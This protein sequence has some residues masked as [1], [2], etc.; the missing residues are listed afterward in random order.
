MAVTY[1]STGTVVFSTGN[2]SPTTPTHN[3]GDLLLLVI[4]TKPDTTPA[5]TPSGWTQL[6]VA[7]GGSGTQG[8]DTGPMRVGIFYRIADGTSLDTTGSITITGNNVSGAQ[9]HVFRS[10]TGAYDIAGVGAADTT[11]GTPFSVTMPS[12]PGLTVGD[13]LYATGIVPTDVGGGTNFSAETVSAAG[14][15]T[16]SLTETAADWASSTGQDMGGWSARGSVVTGTSTGNPTVSATVSG[17]TTNIAGPI[18]L[19]RIREQAATTSITGSE[20]AAISVSESSNVLVTP[21]S[22]GA[23]TTPAYDSVGPWYSG[24]TGFI[25]TSGSWTHTPTGTLTHAVV[26]LG[27]GT[28][29]GSDS[30]A[31]T[32]VTYGGAA[33]TSRGKVHAGGLTTGYVELFTLDVAGGLQQGAQTVSVTRSGGTGTITVTGGSIGITG[34][35]SV[36]LGGTNSGSGI[37]VASSG[38]ISLGSTDLAV[39]GFAAGQA[40]AATTSG[41]TRVFADNNN[42]NSAAGNSAGMYGTSGTGTLTMTSNLVGSDVYGAVTVIFSGSTPTTT[43]SD[44]AAISVT[45]SSSVTALAT[46]TSTESAAISVA[47]AS[48]IFVS[49]ASNDGAAISAVE[50]PNAG[51]AS[52]SFI[53]NKNGAVGNLS[54]ITVTFDNPAVAGNTLVS[55]ISSNR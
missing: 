24:V 40:F 12:N 17:T 28:Q 27:V 53:Q 16:V 26:I 49:L 8:I 38:V 22:G 10:A 5:T 23:A 2:P 31:T 29:S 34:A 18:Y 19:V 35:G 37:T 4:G 54:S 3:V 11:T 50:G 36:A 47:D 30:T 41:G 32:S 21:F 43:P 20:S 45:E 52:G 14:M 13:M 39:T 1:V 48:S 6:G 51:G 25:G 46:Q 55:I 9:V 42:S 33:M 15:T 7:N 44:G